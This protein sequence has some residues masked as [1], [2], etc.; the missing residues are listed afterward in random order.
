M[1]ANVSITTF[2]GLSPPWSLSQLDLDL[3][4]LRDAIQSQNTFSNFFLDTGAAGAY[5]VTLAAGQT[6]T[7]TAGLMVQFLA[8]NANLG[9]STLNYNAL[10]VKNILNLDGTALVAGQ[11][12]AGSVV[13]VIYSGTAWLL[14]S[15]A[16]VPVTG[17]W[18]PIIG[19]TA[20]YNNNTGQFLKI[21]KWY[22][23]NANINI[24]AVG[25]GSTTV[26]SGL[27]ATSTGTAM[28]VQ[29]RVQQSVTNIVSLLGRVDVSNTTITL[30]SRTAASASD[31]ANAIF[32]NSCTVDINGVYVAA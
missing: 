31:A 9:A 4:N 32:Q 29:A 21:G 13:Q 28:V 5:V 25:T 19:G 18:T 3:T 24:L 6:G 10:G 2:A 30:L 22:F 12:A 15:S 17:G 14:L 20:T 1:A 11:I 27:P 16:N 23:I 26:I 7:L 8:A